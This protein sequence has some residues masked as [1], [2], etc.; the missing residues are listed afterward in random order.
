MDTASKT[1]ILIL[2]TAAVIIGLYWFREVLAPF[3]LALFLWLVID[4]F[5]EG[6][7]N[8][9]RI[10]PRWFALL[11]ALLLVT[12]SIGILGYVIIDTANGIVVNSSVYEARLNE[13]AASIF[14]VFSSEPAPTVG[15]L[16]VRANPARFLSS[17]AQS[18]QSLTSD[19]LFVAIYVGFLFGAQSNF[20]A[21]ITAM[22]PD[23]DKLSRAHALASSMRHAIE[24]YLWVQTVT[25]AATA[26]GS[27]VVMKVI[28]VDQAL[29]W[30]FVIFLLNYVPTIGPI[31][32]TILPVLFA[33][34]QFD[35]YWQPGVVLAGVGFFQFSIGTFLQPRM[36]GDSMNLSTLVVILTLSLW[37]AIWG[38]PGMFLSAPLTVMLMMVLSQFDGTRWIAILLSMDGRPEKGLSLAPKP[39]M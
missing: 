29:F 4:G 3:A 32:G 18:L 36:Q 2:A 38:I 28:G 11:L 25:A 16:I 20:A 12:I 5:A 24:K 13:L 30:A 35:S 23:P 39:S 17:I 8:L 14:G 34:V 9:F 10:I 21:K 6:I 15:Q 26:A 1:G 22:F 19:A 31:I 33:L 37:G 27:W 7:E